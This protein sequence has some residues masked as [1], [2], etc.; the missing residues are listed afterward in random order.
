MAHFNGPGVMT[1]G[2]CN[3]SVHP[4]LVCFLACSEEIISGS[5]FDVLQPAVHPAEPPPL[6]AFSVDLYIMVIYMVTDSN[7]EPTSA[8]N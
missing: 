5:M 4:R 2:K 8:A 1:P 3:E 7:C 6:L